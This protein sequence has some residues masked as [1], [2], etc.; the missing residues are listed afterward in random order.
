M[1][2][3]RY[4]VKKWASDFLHSLDEIKKIQSRREFLYLEKHIADE[5]VKKIN[6]A[7]QKI[8]FLDYDGTLVD[9][10][11]H[12]QLAFPKDDLL[13][14]LTDLS[15]LKNSDTVLISGRDRT[16]LNSWFKNIPFRIVAEHG[17]WWRNEKGHWAKIRKLDN[18]WKKNI[19]PLISKYTDLLPGSFI[20]DKENSIAWHY[21]NSDPEQSSFRAQ[22][23]YD[24]ISML[25][26]KKKVE[27]LRGNKV[28]EVKSILVSKGNM[29]MKF[30]NE[31]KYD[32]ILA[33]GDDETDEEMFRT[34]PESSY[35]IKVGLSSSFA[36]YN[37]I[38][39]DE[40]IKL[41]KRI[42]YE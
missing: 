2:L 39:V 37:L 32:F 38:E 24:N 14:L 8:I 20:E 16:T 30:L 22:E 4:N 5:I 19:L 1:R 33:L 9:F 3:K 35:S 15:K 21:R 29:A 27:L 36:R 40:V 10:S 12:P 18:R 13:K 6:S 17:L 31:K 23:V 42:V 7:G 41:L 34:L 25:I 11:H 26:Q 28:L